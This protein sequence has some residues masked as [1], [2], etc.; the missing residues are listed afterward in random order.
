VVSTTRTIRN[1]DKE[2]R[3][4]LEAVTRGL[5]KTP[6]RLRRIV[7]SSELCKLAIAP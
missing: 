6:S 7:Y 1:T 4:P 3:P 5:V 2:D